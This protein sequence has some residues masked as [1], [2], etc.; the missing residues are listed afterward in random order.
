MKLRASTRTGIQ[1]PAARQASN[2]PAISGDIR[3]DNVVALPFVYLPTALSAF[4]AA[5]FSLMDFS[6]FFLS[7]DCFLSCDFATSASPRE[8]ESWSRLKAV[9]LSPVYYL[10]PLRTGTRPERWDVSA[11]CCCADRHTER[12]PRRTRGLQRRQR[13]S[14]CPCLPSQGAISH[15]PAYH[16]LEPTQPTAFRNQRTRPTALSRALT[17]RESVSDLIRTEASGA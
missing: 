8:T 14:Q 9:I 17:A 10:D 13:S 15:R 16:A 4:F 6:G 2:A 1:K 11:A 5:R 12:K 7:F 3:S